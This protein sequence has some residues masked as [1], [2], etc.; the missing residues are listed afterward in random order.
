MKNANK[1][2]KPFY[3][4]IFPIIVFVILVIYTISF[5]TPLF[6]T[7][8]TSF[9]TMDDYMMSPFGFPKELAGEV[10][11]S[12]I[13]RIF[14][15]YSLA[16]KFIDAE[17]TVITSAGIKTYELHMPQ[18]LA[19]TLIYTVGATLLTT[20]VHAISA[21]LAAR[22]N[23][24]PLIKLLYPIVIITMIMPIVGNLP[25]SLQ[26]LRKL[27]F[28]DNVV[29]IWIAR[30]SFLGTN[31]LIFYATFRGISWDYAEAAFIDGASHLDVLLRIMLP[32]AGTTISS[33]F[34]LCFITYWNDWQINIINLPNYPM[35]AYALYEYQNDLGTFTSQLTYQ[36]AGCMIVATPMFILF[37]LFRKKLMGSLTIG[38][39]KG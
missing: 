22:Y 5:L 11:Q 14:N 31:F 19:N 32:L 39:L 38:G 9:K 18:L 17:K 7:I 23:Q 35:V 4:Q 15:N 12:V 8:M 3:K 30:G 21:Y 1:I 37:V 6:W 13:A 27:R 34:V 36:M 2:K 24:F 10:G 16:W 28:Y 26:V 33:L 29:G 25:S 20:F